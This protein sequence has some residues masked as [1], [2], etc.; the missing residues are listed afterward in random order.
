[1]KPINA[2]PEESIYKLNPYDRS[3]GR[4]VEIPT[5]GETGETWDSS[6][7]D[8]LGD[9]FWSYFSDKEARAEIPD[10]RRINKRL[11]DWTKE[12][13]N[14]NNAQT[15]GNI[16][17]SSYAGSLLHNAL[18]ND[19]SIK[20][21]LEKQAE[22]EAKQAEAEA[23]ENAARALD[24]IGQGNA[25]REMRESSQN[26][27][28][29]ASQALQE[30]ESALDNLEGSKRGEAVRASAIQEA[31]EEG[32]K[33]AEICKSWGLEKGAG[34]A[35]DSNVIKKTLESYREMLPIIGALLGRVKGIAQSVKS[36]KIKPTDIVTGDGYTREMTRIFPGEIALLRKDVNPSIRAV[37]MGEYCDRGLIGMITGTTGN[38]EGGI[39]LVRDGSGSMRGNPNNKASALC[40]GLLETARESNQFCDA[41]TFSS[42]GDLMTLPE[43]PTFQDKIEWAVNIPDGG[44]DFDFALNHAMDI[45]EQGGNERLE[46]CDIVM[47][48]DGYGDINAETKNRMEEFKET[49]GMRFLYIAVG[50]RTGAGSRFQSVMNKVLNMTDE[51][52]LE[53]LAEECA[54][55]MWD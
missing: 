41:F 5:E 8:L 37:K 45:L 10:S 15:S 54:R 50:N 35:L 36:S 11:I 4:Y 43:N 20:E 49:Y 31:N 28:M 51:I 30:A 39:I 26:K 24:E 6:Q 47:I 27:A 34:N 25:A 52:P 3:L 16:L 40:L 14:W 46:S 23:E 12:S 19:P 29:E 17:A 9:S 38:K 48:T 42:Y 18:L 7:K 13:P 33:I 44:T 32:E 2:N 53:S 1:M 55:F 21:A 22:A